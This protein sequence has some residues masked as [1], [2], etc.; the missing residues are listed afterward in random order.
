MS[1][2]KIERKKRKNESI[3]IEE[4]W[5]NTWEATVQHYSYRREV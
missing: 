4:Y 5:L 2:E 1:S 3:R